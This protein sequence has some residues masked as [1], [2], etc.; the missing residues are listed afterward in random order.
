MIK[1][2]DEFMDTLREYDPK[3]VAECSG[4][5]EQTIYNWL[6]GKVECPRLTTVLKVA[7]VIGMGINF[8][9][10]LTSGRKAAA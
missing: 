6:G 4:V 3:S 2:L 1:E 7:P 8:H 5:S 10:I 9:K